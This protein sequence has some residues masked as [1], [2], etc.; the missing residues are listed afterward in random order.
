MTEPYVGEI[1][2]FA[3]P[4]TPVGWLACDGAFYD[5]SQYETLYALLGTTFGGNGQSTFAVPDLRGRVAVNMGQAPKLS[6]YRP[7][8]QAGT[9]LAS[10]Q[11]A[12]LPAH[13]HAFEASSAAGTI[14]APGAAA[15]LAG[16]SPGL[17]Y[18]ASA[19]GET[20]ITLP[21]STVVQVGGGVPHNNLA[22]TLTVNICIAAI[23]LYPT[24]N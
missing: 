8:E 11:V 10:L 9:E 19:A 18:Q 23:G 5:I 17:M 13:T 4:R 21:A 20:A 12:N 22:P 3:F 14:G 16:L 6:N 7:G 1:R 24:Q 2:M 15:V